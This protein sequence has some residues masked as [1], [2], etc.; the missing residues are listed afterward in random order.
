MATIGEFLISLGVDSSELQKGLWKAK[1]DLIDTKLT[2]TALIVSMTLLIKKTMDYVVMLDKFSKTTGLLSQELQKWGAMAKLANVS[3]DAVAGSIK[4]LNRNRIDFMMGK[5]NL[6]PYALLGIDPRSKPFEILDKLRDK[7]NRLD[8][9]LASNLMSQ[10]GVSEEMLVMFKSSDE[11]WQRFNQGLMLTEKQQKSMMKYNQ[12][13]QLFKL[14]LDFIGKKLSIVITSFLRPLLDITN[15][16]IT[17]FSRVAEVLTKVFVIL[18]PLTITFKALVGLFDNG[19]DALDFFITA[20][21]ILLTIVSPVI[22]II[23][24][25]GLAIEDLYVWFKGGDSLFKTWAL[26]LI[27]WGKTAVDYIKNAFQNFIDWF[28]DSWAGK[29]IDKLGKAKD[30]IKDMFG[31]EKVDIGL[32]RQSQNMSN[33]NNTANNNVNS[34]SVIQVNSIEDAIR[35]KREL[36]SNDMMIVGGLR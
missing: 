20:L 3:I 15:K 11:I 16:L 1:K 33:I 24:L 8:P 5:G 30:Y 35:I 25:L 36:D 9:A 18:S 32:P 10:L 21:S 27:S 26:N 31:D 4:N 17:I 14:N 2:V 7:V 29:I 23:M 19:N 6:T 13:W 34:S 12:S 22:G 28:N